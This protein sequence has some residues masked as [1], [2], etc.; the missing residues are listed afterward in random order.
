MPRICWP[1]HV[2]GDICTGD[3]LYLQG[4]FIFCASSPRMAQELLQGDPYMRAIVCFVDTCTNDVPQML[5]IAYIH[6]H[7]HQRCPTYAGHCRFST[8]PAQAMPHICRPLQTFVDICINGAQ[9][10]PAI[11][12][13]YRHMH[14][15]CS[16]YAGH[17][18]FLLTSAPKMR[19]ICGPSHVFVYTCT[20]DGP[21]SSAF[22]GFHLHPHQGCSPFVGHRRFSTTS[23]STMLNICPHMRAIAY[24]HLHPDQRC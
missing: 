12:C 16:T 4:H 19:P 17:C 10:M 5:A 22:A 14:R 18:R 8:T 1:P 15:R 24:F 11:A 20:D 23:A 6:L 7:L 13:F 21:H 9:H 2:F 3:G